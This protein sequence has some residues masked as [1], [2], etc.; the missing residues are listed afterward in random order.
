[1]IIGR[2]YTDFVQKTQPYIEEII[3]KNE[4]LKEAI[5]AEKEVNKEIVSQIKDIEVIV[6]DLKIGI[7]KVEEEINQE[8]AAEEK[9]ELAKQ[10]KQ[11]NKGKK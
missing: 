1:M 6:G 10:M 7:V 4:H 11:F 2:K 8:K 9:L 5:K 3:E